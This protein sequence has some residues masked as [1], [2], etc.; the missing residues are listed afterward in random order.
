MKP[1]QL[2]YVLLALLFIVPFARADQLEPYEGPWRQG[3]SNAGDCSKCLITVRR[4]GINLEVVANN[5]WRATLRPTPKYLRE[6]SPSVEGEGFWETTIGGDRKKISIKVRLT[7]DEG[8]LRMALTAGYPAERR[9]IE[10]T[11]ER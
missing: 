5:G 2:A 1:V 8:K 3:R 6:K 11:F 10:A 7:R 4:L 9:T